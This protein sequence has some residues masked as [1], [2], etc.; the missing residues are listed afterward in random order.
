MVA[1]RSSSDSGKPGSSDIAAEEDACVSLA[2]DGVAVCDATE[3]AAVESRLFEAEVDDDVPRLTPVT[4]D[5]GE[6]C[7]STRE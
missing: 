4:F 5:A 6:P 2:R 3:V 1:V 7:S